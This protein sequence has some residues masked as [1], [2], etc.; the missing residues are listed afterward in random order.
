MDD[1]IS[2]S[3]RDNQVKSMI[4]NKKEVTMN[5]QRLEGEDILPI[6]PPRA[7][8][9]TNIFPMTKSIKNRL[10]GFHFNSAYFIFFKL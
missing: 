9:T 6:I 3:D 8:T 2:Q 10:D 4:T 1:I 5:V 7:P